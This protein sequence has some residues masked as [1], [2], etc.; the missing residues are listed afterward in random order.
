M[1]IHKHDI[2]V[3][4]VV[5]LGVDPVCVVPCDDL[6]NGARYENVARF[7]QHVLPLVRLRPG[8]T[9][10]R[11]V[12][13]QNTNYFTAVCLTRRSQYVGAERNRVNCEP[14][15]KKWAGGVSASCFSFLRDHEPPFLPCSSFLITS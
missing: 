5:Y 2:P 14:D 15:L 6:L 3:G 12:L 4:A 9:N 1:R 10:D 11:P 7:E 13:L 8:E